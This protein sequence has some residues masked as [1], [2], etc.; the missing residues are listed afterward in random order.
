LYRRLVGCGVRG[1]ALVARRSTSDA[2]TAII[3][4][5]VPGLARFRPP[6]TL[7]VL[8]HHLFELRVELLGTKVALIVLLFETV[9]ATVYFLN[10]NLE[11]PTL[12][13]ISP[14]SGR[15]WGLSGLDFCSPGRKSG[16]D[17][18]SSGRK[19]GFGDEPLTPQI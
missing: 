7:I 5:P 14:Q 19:S 9:I 10:V 16:F 1:N 8:H 18:C 2:G 4:V 3:V 12:Q 15:L 6:A 11:L 13:K 17:F